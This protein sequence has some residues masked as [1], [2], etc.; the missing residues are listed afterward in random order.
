MLTLY[1]APH[2]TALA[3]RIALEEAG[4]DYRIERIDLR[5]GQQRTEQYLA[6]NPSGRVPALTTPKGTIAENP[7]ILAFIA[8]SFP[9]ARLAP[10]DDPFGF[11]RV[12][13]FNSYVATTLHVAHAHGRRGNRWADD[14]AAIEAMKRKVPETVGACFALIENNW[15]QG[16]WV[17]G[18]DYSVCDPYLFCF[19]Q[20]IESDGVDP[21]RF[22]K[23]Q[24][25]FA[26]M[27]ERPAVQR[28]LAGEK[29]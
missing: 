1:F 13:A 5:G 4:A 14:P 2:T 3:P 24:A 25:H 12:Q 18:A 16:P 26:R 27:K 10:L 15:L 21:K 6:V 23:V 29:A 22:P 28:A 7:A 17:T 8:Q 9:A 20:W 19:A 11:A